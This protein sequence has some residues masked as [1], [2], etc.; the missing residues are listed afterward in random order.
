MTEVW[1]SRLLD[2]KSTNS[3]AVSARNPVNARNLWDWNKRCGPI[4][5]WPAGRHSAL[6]F[7]PA[8]RPGW[9]W[10]VVSLSRNWASWK[11]NLYWDYMWNI[12]SWIIWVNCCLCL[13][14][15]CR[16]CCLCRILIRVAVSNSMCLCSSDSFYF[17]PALFRSVWESIWILPNSFIVIELTLIRKSKA[18]LPETVKSQKNWVWSNFY[19]L[20]KQVTNL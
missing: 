5:F 9:R 18:Q 8:K 7:T 4:R 1:K 2:N 13:W 3:K 12:G 11:S 10:T 16:F 14:F 17:Y 15:C 20:I 6:W 19:S